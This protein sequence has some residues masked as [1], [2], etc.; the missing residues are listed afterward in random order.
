MNDVAKRGSENLAREERELFIFKKKKKVKKEELK[1]YESDI[2]HS[3]GVRV[4]TG[5]ITR[6]R[7]DISSQNDGKPP[8]YKRDE[9]R[10]QFIAY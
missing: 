2:W 10:T 3:P 4:S 6:A 9:R 5:K 7:S 1:L 8:S